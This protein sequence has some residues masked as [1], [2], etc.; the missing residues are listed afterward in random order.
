M[1]INDARDKFKKLEMETDN[2]DSQ[3]IFKHIFNLLTELQNKNLS[4]NE[5]SVIET[6]L[7]THLSE[8]QTTQQAQN[9]LKMIKKVLMNDLFFAPANHYIALCL[10]I[11][12]AIG[13]GLGILFGAPF[14]MPMGI[15]YGLVGGSGIGLIVGVFIGKYLDQKVENKNRVLVN[16]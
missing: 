11:G 10:G 2:P 16:L 1:S 7:E 5:Q 8:V 12:L 6:H 4:Q 14:G 13:A 15:I 3:K 9:S